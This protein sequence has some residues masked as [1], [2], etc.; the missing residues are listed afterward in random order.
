MRV[1][2]FMP[3]NDNPPYQ[4]FY[5]NCAFINIV[6]PGGGT[7]SEFTRFPGAYSPTDPGLQVPSEQWFRADPREMRLTQ[8][9]QPGPAVWTG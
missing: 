1:E 7:P 2:H 4:Q 3:T 5:V 9:K 6:G 8:Y